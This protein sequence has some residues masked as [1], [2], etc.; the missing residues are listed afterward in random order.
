MNRILSDVLSLWPNALKKGKIRQVLGER[1]LGLISGLSHNL[2]RQF[3][4]P[5]FIALLLTLTASKSQSK[6]DS[7]TQCETQATESPQELVQE[8]SMSGNDSHTPPNPEGGG[9]DSTADP[10]DGPKGIIYARVSS[11]GQ[12]NGNERADGNGEDDGSISGQISELEDLAEKQGIALPY[13]PITDEAK[14]QY[15]TKP[16]S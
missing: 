3:S 4:S 6:L 15:L 10:G 7:F 9:S 12:L 14:T 11:G 16:V 5:L 13:D 2:K 8:N 1:I